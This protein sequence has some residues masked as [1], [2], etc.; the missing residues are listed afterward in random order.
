MC[1]MC[2]T[3]VQ[4]LV[5]VWQRWLFLGLSS[6][7]LLCPPSLL[8]TA[9]IY[10]C[11]VVFPGCPSKLP[12]A[13]WSV[14]TVG[15]CTQQALR[16]VALFSSFCDQFG[17]LLSNAQ[18]G[19]KWLWGGAS[20]GGLNWWWREHWWWWEACQVSGVRLIALD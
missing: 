5:S 16:G 6:L 18:C 20:G 3:C 13:A 10:L 2:V 9:S 8:R 4:G 15:V 12:V 11:V 19:G 7:S 14:V 17:I 1:V